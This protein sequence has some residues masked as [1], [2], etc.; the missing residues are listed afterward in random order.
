MKLAVFCGTVLLSITPALGADYVVKR[1]KDAPFAFKTSVGANVN[2]GSKL[3][4]ETILL[5]DP[6][7]PVQVEK[8]S[9]KMDFGRNNFEYRVSSNV[10]IRSPIVAVS[11]RHIMYDVFGQHMK[12]LANIEVK[13]LGPGP[14]TIN[15]AW[16]AYG[17]EISEFLTA[18]TYVSRVRLADGTQWVYNENG[19]LAALR[20]LRLEQRVGEKKEEDKEKR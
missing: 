15:G 19:V 12:N 18:V 3:T 11:V 6:D 2:A 13:D 20:S 7:C 10:Q 8:T 1:E 14:A 9:V 5:N 17:N 16:N 4:R